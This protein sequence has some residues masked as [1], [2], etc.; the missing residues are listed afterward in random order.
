MI[1]GIDVDAKGFKRTYLDHMLK[2]AYRWKSVAM[3]PLEKG[4]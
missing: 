2:E 3:S 1:T 4:C